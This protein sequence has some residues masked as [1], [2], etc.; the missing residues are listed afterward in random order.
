[1]VEV[2]TDTVEELAD[3][4]AAQIKL[5]HLELSVDLRLAGKRAARLALFLPPLAVGYAF[6]M[7]ALAR[8]S[9]RTGVG[10]ARWERSPRCR[11]PSAASA[12]SA[13]SPRFAGRPFWN[14]PA[15]T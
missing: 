2:A 10:S 5:A 7:A 8:F 14:E 13:R 9:R 4:L 1:M 6:A 3:L 11:S 12:F 15:P